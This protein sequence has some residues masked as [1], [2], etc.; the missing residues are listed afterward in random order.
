MGGR[1]GPSDAYLLKEPIV[2][3]LFI[4]APSTSP[5]KSPVCGEGEEVWMNDGP[6]HLTSVKADAAR[7]LELTGKGQDFRT[8]V[9]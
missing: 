5:K 3:S 9:K 8:T 2:S 4:T 1:R 7:V 6:G